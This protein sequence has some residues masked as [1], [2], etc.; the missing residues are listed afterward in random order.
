MSEHHWNHHWH[1][2]RSGLPTQT[3]KLMRNKWDFQSTVMPG[4][5]RLAWICEPSFLVL[6]CAIALIFFVLCSW[7]SCNTC[8]WTKVPSNI[9]NLY[10]NTWSMYIMSIIFPMVIY[11]L[12]ILCI[13]I[14]C[15]SS[16]LTRCL[17]YKYYLDE[18][19]LPPVFYMIRIS[20]N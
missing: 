20:A 19:I 6:G 14:F 10:Q 1:T 11:I 8:E 9:K 17:G 13:W 4:M 2:N 7:S 18:I 16:H 15:C 5:L 3:K 12:Y